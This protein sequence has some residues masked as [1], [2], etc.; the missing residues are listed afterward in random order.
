MLPEEETHKHSVSVVEARVTGHRHQ[1][2]LVGT[3]LT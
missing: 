3:Y 2:A 1:G